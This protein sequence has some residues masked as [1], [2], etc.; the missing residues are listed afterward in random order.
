MDEKKK[1]EV[2]SQKAEDTKKPQTLV[3]RCELFEQ[4]D[5]AGLIPSNCRRIIIDLMVNTMAKIYYETYADDRLIDINLPDLLQKT[6]VVSSAPR[7][8]LIGK[9]DCSSDYE[10]AYHL[11]SNQ[12]R[13]LMAGETVKLISDGK[14]K[15]VSELKLSIEALKEFNNLKF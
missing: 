14:L 5:K 13:A 9:R 4:F 12:V 1:A 15:R 3:P 6:Q 8:R 7:S 2:S 11:D 10:S